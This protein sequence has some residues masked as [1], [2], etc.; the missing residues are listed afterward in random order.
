MSDELNQLL[1]ESDGLLERTS[2]DLHELVGKSCHGRGFNQVS[3][4]LDVDGACEA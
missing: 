1:R 3:Q 2:I 4:F